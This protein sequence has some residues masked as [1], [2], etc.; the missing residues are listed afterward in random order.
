MGERTAEA[1]QIDRVTS[2]SICRAIGERLQANLG[3]EAPLPSKLQR[4]IDELHRQEER[5]KN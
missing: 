5:G 3:P 1:S 4:L 2:S